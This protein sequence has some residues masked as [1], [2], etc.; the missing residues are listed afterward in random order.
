MRRSGL[1]AVCVVLAALMTVYGCSG[2]DDNPAG[3][4]GQP[5]HGEGTVGAG[6]GT[7]E[8][9]EEIALDIPAD[10][11]AA[12]TD[13]TI[14]ENTSPTRASPPHNFVSSA[15]TV[16]PSGTV[17]AVDATVTIEYDPSDLGRADE[18]DVVICCDEGSG[19]E[20]LETA[21]DAQSN[22][23]SACPGSR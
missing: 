17:F 13:F 12:D 10:A 19:W 22:E 9:D 3:S 8:I 21:V 1:V 6:G 11:L 23:A 18:E 4:N 7:V 15:Y 14:D 20:E 16:E 5:S 2:G